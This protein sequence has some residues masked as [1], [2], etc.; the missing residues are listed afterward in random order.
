M[1]PIKLRLRPLLVVLP[2]S[3]AACAS[4]RSDRPLFALGPRTADSAAAVHARPPAAIERLPDQVVH[5]PA[6][7]F[8]LTER[9]R[10]QLVVRT[11]HA[12]DDRYWNE[13]RPLARHQLESAGLPAADVTF[14]LREVDASR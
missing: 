6:E 8:A 10:T 2:L 7:R 9:L 14:L 4:A 5:D 11:R 12:S 3:T 13:L 1:I